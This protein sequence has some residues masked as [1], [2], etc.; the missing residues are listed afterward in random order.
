MLTWGPP[1]IKFNAETPKSPF[2]DIEN[3]T[4]LTHDPTPPYHRAWVKKKSYFHIGRLK[5]SVFKFPSL[6]V[7]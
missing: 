1:Y 2:G 3:L 4:K 7:A 6:G 5:A